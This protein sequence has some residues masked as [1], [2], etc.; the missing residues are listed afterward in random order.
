MYEKKMIYFCFKIYY[1]EKMSLPYEVTKQIL[2]KMKVDDVLTYCRQNR[3]TKDICNN[4]EFWMSYIEANYDMESLANIIGWDKEKLSLFEYFGTREI[5][6][7]GELSKYNIGIATA[8]LL[9]N[10]RVITVEIR[11]NHIPHNRLLLLP[12]K[13]RHINMCVHS[14]D[15]PQVIN[16]ILF[17][18]DYVLYIDSNNELAVRDLTSE[19]IPILTVAGNPSLIQDN[20]KNIQIN[21]VTINGIPLLD[22]MT[23]IEQDYID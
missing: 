4:E 23:S 22:L 21:D 18:G 13:Y 12:S 7:E 10:S 2:F 1:V 16:A 6:R 11:Y 14:I 9:E 19:T 17:A 5:I 3:E 15:Y 8:I 20:L